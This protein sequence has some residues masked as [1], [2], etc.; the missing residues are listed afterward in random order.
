MICNVGRK[1]PQQTF[2]IFKT[3]GGPEQEKKSKSERK[4]G[5][6]GGGGAWRDFPF[7]SPESQRM[8]GK[9]FYVKDSMSQTR[10]LTIAKLSEKKKFSK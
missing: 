10:R 7:E 4:G 6:G 9:A 1:V 5:G 3:D 2:V 8:V